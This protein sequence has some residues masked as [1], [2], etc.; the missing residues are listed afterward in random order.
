MIDRKTLGRTLSEMTRVQAQDLRT[1]K[2]ATA[3][4][5]QP[6]SDALPAAT[7]QVI[8]VASGKGGTG[9]SVVTS[10]LAVAL[11]QE[12]TNVFLLD[13][14]L[15]LAN[16]HILMG[17]HPKHDISSVLSG[18][19]R[20]RDIVVDCPAGVRLIAGGSGFSELSDL[21][22]GQ[23]RYL[24]SEMQGFEEEGSILLVDLAAGI[25]PQ[26]M[27]FMNA[28][29]KLLLVTTPDATALL[30]AYATIKT[31]AQHGVV[32]EVRVIINR[33]RDEKDAYAAFDKIEAAVA[34]HLQGIA[35][36]LFSWLP[37][38]WY[39]QRSVACQQPV[40]LLHPRSFVTRCFQTMAGRISASHQRWLR[41]QRE[42]AAR[43]DP[44]VVRDRSY[45]AQL[46]RAVFH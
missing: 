9:K 34:K 1:E 42:A 28:S 36:S 22:D 30:D 4:S 37:M 41:R 12:G 25:S 16:A 21:N 18:E 11:A 14:D 2:N 44:S 26:V 46:S 35:V 6:D 23:F 20:L 5:A 10:N 39:I 8:C 7:C 45:F 13:A 33:A 38:N 31:L 43:N 17:V 32:K 19:M 29:H 3:V 27:R 15:G 24:A 40:V